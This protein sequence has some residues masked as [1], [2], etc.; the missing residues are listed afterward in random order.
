MLSELQITCIKFF[1]GIHENMQW[2]STKVL[3]ENW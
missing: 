3:G 1:Q 2:V